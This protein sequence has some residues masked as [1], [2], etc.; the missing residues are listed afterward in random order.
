M[1]LT[2]CGKKSECDYPTR[3]V[4]LYTKSFNS[5][6]S[7]EYNYHLNISSEL[8]YY[9]PTNPKIFKGN[10]NTFNIFKH[11]SSE[12]VYNDILLIINYNNPGF[13]FVNEYMDNCTK[14]IFRILF[15]YTRIILEIKILM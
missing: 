13:L 3:H 14:N 9:L 10:N 7:K 8:L 11:S 5:E 1:L 12:K 4:H 15:I 2:G 6:I